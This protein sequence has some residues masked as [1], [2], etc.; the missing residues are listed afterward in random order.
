[1]WGIV[2]QNRLKKY[3]KITTRDRFILSVGKD[4]RSRDNINKNFYIISNI[5]QNQKLSNSQSFIVIFA[6]FSYYCFYRLWSWCLF[7]KL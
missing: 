5:M 6:F 2:A 3:F 4:F 7:L 1:M